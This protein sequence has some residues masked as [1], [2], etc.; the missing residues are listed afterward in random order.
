M[1]CGRRA[2]QQL[3]CDCWKL[4][5]VWSSFA[6][7]ALSSCTPR[8]IVLR[9]PRW[10]TIVDAPPFMILVFSTFDAPP[11]ADGVGVGWAERRAVVHAVERGGGG[12]GG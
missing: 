4:T 8:V 11:C 10:F 5:P 9:A 7:L 1:F 6:K 2:R 3:A 12:G